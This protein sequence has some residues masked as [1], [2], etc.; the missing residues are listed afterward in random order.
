[1]VVYH[2]FQNI[3]HGT[4]VFN[5]DNNNK[6]HC[7][8][9]KSFHNIT[10]FTILLVWFYVYLSPNRCNKNRSRSLTGYNQ[11]CHDSNGQ[12]SGFIDKRFRQEVA[13]RQNKCPQGDMIK[14]GMRARKRRQLHS[15]R[16]HTDTCTHTHTHTHMQTEAHTHMQTHTHTRA[17]THTQNAD[18]H[19]HTHTHARRHTETHTRRHRHAHTHTHKHADT[20]RHTHTHTQ[21]RR[22]AR[23]HTRGSL[24]SVLDVNG[25]GTG[26]DTQ[27]Q[28]HRHTDTHTHTHTHTHRRILTFCSGCLWHRHSGWWRT[29][30]SIC[31]KFSPEDRLLKNNTSGRLAQT[32]T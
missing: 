16:V 2:G 12:R 4:R 26:T 21:R 25:T 1:M 24:R 8:S 19:T 32:T 6:K 5:T 11:R 22:R 9:S 23:M 31:Q 30:G 28:T 10:V 14:P 29:G 15:S 7:L 27:T 20:D 3:W 17:R 18:T 13:K